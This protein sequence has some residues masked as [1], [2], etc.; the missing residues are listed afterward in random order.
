MVEFIEG[1]IEFHF[2]KSHLFRV[3]HVDGAVGAIAPSSKLIH[4]SVFSE[5]APVPKKTVHTVTGGILGAEVTEKREGRQ[6]IFREVEVDLV[7]SAETA[8]A[9][10]TWLDDKIQESQRQQQ[11][12]AATR[13]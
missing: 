3:I 4:M 10:R 5:R 2:E 11:I 13:A 1:E 7:F 9:I 6:G 12:I 8:I